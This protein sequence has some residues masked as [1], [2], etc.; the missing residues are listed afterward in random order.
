MTNKEKIKQL[1][2]TIKKLSETQ[3]YS[4]SIKEKEI[5]EIF[6]SKIGG[7]PYWKS[8]IENYPKNSEGKNMFL[9]AQINFE[10]E[11]TKAPLPSKGLL[12]F[13]ISDDD[14]MGMDFD[15]QV[16][17]KNFRIIY[18]EKI[19]YSITKEFI[20][21]L[22]IPDS[23]KAN[24]YPVNGEYKISLNKTKT[25]INYYDFNF[26]KIF[27]KAYKEVFGKKLKPK[28]RYDEVL[29]QEEL[30]ILEEELEEDSRHKMLGYAYFTQ[31]DPRYMEKYKK[32]DT[33]LLQLDSEDNYI[34]WGDLGVA[35]FFINR[36]SLEEKNFNDVLYNWDCT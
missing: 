15:D 10:K 6:D 23:N 8:N 19:D 35:N 9:L 20:E 18:H 21:K 26:D 2:E 24:N 16:K 25:Y 34:M 1:S 33:L 13:Y 7:L 36:K 5:P 11:N 4:I 30:D 22:N 12:Q 3:C 32:Y 27:A 17:Q 14:L 29:E 31:E 28:E